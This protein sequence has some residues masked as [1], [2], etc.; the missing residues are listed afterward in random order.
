MGCLLCGLIGLAGPYW[1]LYLMS[2]SLFADYH[3]GGATFSLLALLLLFNVLLALLW[4]GFRLHGRELRFITAMTLTSGSIVT[5]GLVA[6]LIPGM[7]APYYHA[8]EA[9]QIHVR[10]WPHLPKWLFA[11]DPGGG[12]VAIRKFWNGLPGGEPIPW[13]P[14]IVP[15]VC[16]GVF[17]LALFGCMIALMSIMRKQWVDYE[18]L[19]YPIAQ[20]PAELCR[21]VEAPRARSSILRSRAFWIGGGLAFLLGSSAGLRHYFGFFP[22]LNLKHSVEG[23]G[24]MA[25]PIQVGPVV[26]GLTFLI[27]NRVAFSV[28]FLALLSWVLR[29]FIRAYNFGLDEWML[30]GVVGHPELQHVAM[31]AM[32]AF[33]VG[34][35]WL[36]RRHLLRVVRCATGRDPGYDAGE[37]TSYRTALLVFGVGLVVALVWLNRVGMSLVATAGLLLLTLVVYYAMARIIA[38]CGLPAINSPV[39][40]SPYMASLFGSRLLG[41]ETIIGLGAHLTWHADLR[42][43]PLSGAGHGMYLT[44]RRSAG[45]F[46]SM[47]GGLLITY[48]VAS[49]FTIYLGYRHGASAMQPWYIYNSSHLTWFWTSALSQADADPSYAGMVWTGVGCVIM[50]A[51]MVAQRALFWWPLHPVGF[52]TSGAFLVTHFW[53]SI[54]LAWLIKVLVVYL[55]GQAAYRTGRRFFIGL[56]LGNFAVGGVWAIVDTFTGSTGNA[57]FQL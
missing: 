39:V 37:P 45:L 28:W 17:I 43:S 4:K 16:W 8:S 27:P 11:L 54:F 21:A 29:S 3:T 55:G 13:G 19:S 48:V 41:R 2:S 33:A 42:N 46:W 24:P 57:V 30:Y 51:L 44:G 18:H 35:V 52:L 38:Q 6:Y 23:L 7:T 49:L 47:M 22:A 15:L 10:L 9:N 25:L 53:F 26:L 32:T 36:A 50:A 12:R 31:G 56:V 1:C 14:W 5:S 34:S 20:V 40:P